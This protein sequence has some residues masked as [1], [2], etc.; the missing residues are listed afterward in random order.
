MSGAPRQPRPG[1]ARAPGG[2]AKYTPAETDPRAALGL[3]SGRAAR[4]AAAAGGAG[5][6]DTEMAPKDQKIEAVNEK[7]TSIKTVMTKNMGTK[8]KEAGHRTDTEIKQPQ[9]CSLLA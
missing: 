4:P 7:L 6:G 1:G 2:G 8:T 5:A 3:P 9:A